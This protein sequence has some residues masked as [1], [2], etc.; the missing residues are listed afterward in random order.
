METSAPRSFRAGGV[1]DFLGILA[2]VFAAFLLPPGVS[3]DRDGTA[4]DFAFWETSHGA[5]FHHIHSKR[6]PG[7]S[8]DPESVA[9]PDGPE[10]PPGLPASAHFTA[11]SIGTAKIELSQRLMPIANSTWFHPP[12]TGPPFS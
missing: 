10:G 9:L 11:G 8:A 1:K 4:Q 5:G 12:A 7:R 3:A 2:V 6:S